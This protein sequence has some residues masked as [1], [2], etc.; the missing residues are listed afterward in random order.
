MTRATTTLR[1]PQA[2][3]TLAQPPIGPV[4]P[5][6]VAAHRPWEARHVRML[7]AADLVAGVVAGATAFLVR[8]GSAGGHYTERYVALSALLP[9]CWLAALSVARAYEPRLL[10][11]GMTEYQQ[12]LRAGARLT[13]GAALLSYALHADLAR[14]Y[15]IVAFTL[16]TVLSMTLRF[17]LRRRL[18]RERDRGAAVRR[19]LA[20]GHASAV[21]ELTRLLNRRYYHGLKVVAAC[22]PDEQAGT[23]LDVPLLGAPSS[24]G[25]LA[26][27]VNADTVVVLSMPEF[28]GAAVR[29]LAWE[30]ERDDVDLLIASSLVDVTGHRIAIRQVD[31]LPLLHVEHPHLT[32]GRRVLKTMW[33]TAAAAL[34]V[35]LLA[36]VVA[37]LAALVKLDS[38]GPA[39]YRQTRVGRG[40]REFRM[41]KMRTMV[42]GADRQAHLLRN[43]SDGVLFK[44]RR[45]P[46]VTRAGQFLRRFSLDELPQ[47]FNVLRG[48]MSLVG[49]R[50][51]L[52]QEVA[53]YPDD[54]R[55]RLVVKPGITGLWQVSGRSDLSWADS[56]RL[57]LSYVEN[58]SLSL[59]L[60]IL[61]RTAVV[62]LRGSGAY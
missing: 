59:D 54:M 53:L 62:V 10:F 6:R 14:T 61:L 49:P 60:L 27:S 39:F 47:I 22:V 20:V 29:R 19:V 13:C 35:V 31:G 41:I 43:E 8:F 32:G 3:A 24:A 57:D 45:D 40:G 18:R 5:G 48:E 28:D 12:T 38:P 42:V 7:V 56:V 16:T 50:P 9:F 25:R 2:S 30:L 51:P 1:T 34:T 55:R 44:V 36:P 26:E 17:A 46:R 15:F 23:A 52:P 33:E 58:W 37:V 21:A 11:V 4:K